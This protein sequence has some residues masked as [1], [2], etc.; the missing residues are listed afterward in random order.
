[1]S[2]EASAMNA[3]ERLSVNDYFAAQ[4]AK[5]RLSGKQAAEEDARAQESEAPA[6]SDATAPA[7][8]EMPDAEMEC[9]APVQQPAAQLR[10][11]SPTTATGEGIKSVRARSPLVSAGMPAHIE[12]PAVDLAF[13]SDRVGGDS[14]SP[15]GDSDE[16][17]EGAV[18]TASVAT[19]RRVRAPGSDEDN[20]AAVKRRKSFPGAAD[21]VKPSSAPSARSRSPWMPSEREISKRMGTNCPPGASLLYVPNDIRDDDEARARQFA[22]QE[23]RRDY[24]VSLFHELLFYKSKSG[25]SAKSKISA[26]QA[27]AQSWN[28]FVENFNAKPLAYRK[29]VEK[30]R[31]A[32]ERYGRGGLMIRLHDM[33][34]EA[35]VPCAIPEG[36]ECLKCPAGARRLPEGE[37][38]GYSG[39]IVP[40]HILIERD[41]LFPPASSPEW[42]PNRFEANVWASS[43]APRTRAPSPERPRAGRSLAPKYLGEEYIL[44]NEYE[45]ESDLGSA[46]PSDVQRFVPQSSAS[47]QPRRAAVAVEVGR[48]PST[49]YQSS[50]SL[51][52]R[53]LLVKISAL[54]AENERR[55]REIAEGAQAHSNLVMRFEK[56]DKSHS[57]LLAS[58]RRLRKRLDAEAVER[59]AAESARLSRRSASSRR[60][61]TPSSPSSQGSGSGSDHHL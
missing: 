4:Q 8:A 18:P 28:A 41:R 16:S 5:K 49:T 47:R 33:C 23:E 6:A 7:M 46:Q 2:A 45:N 52:P 55:A 54:E 44:S 12:V 61:R 37:Y 32:W 27:L 56:L 34:M 59:R 17:E 42:R 51:D 35:G 10:T 25:A 1:M 31:V 58:Y 11:S 22:S 29:R 39:T 26:D 43:A 14:L 48:F 19:P 50:G 60:R 20:G 3:E 53:D 9:K 30:A 21:D 57:E 36:R 40:E 38:R 15:L 13:F 24:Y